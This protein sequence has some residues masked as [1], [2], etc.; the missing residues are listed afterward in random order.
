MDD[1]IEF[2]SYEQ[3]IDLHREQLDL[4]GGRDGVLDD[5][6]VRSSLAQASMRAFGR[7]LHDDVAHM[8]AAYL[9]HFAVN[10]GFIDGNKRIALV[11]CV[12]F[13]AINGYE[14][15]TTDDEA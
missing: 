1:A 4:F 5:G 2:L 9:Y 7:Y 13:L 10:Q 8:A 11:S 3:I 6:V 15:S 12:T 14:L